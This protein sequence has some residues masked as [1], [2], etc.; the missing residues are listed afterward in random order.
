M[1]IGG[2]KMSES[3]YKAQIKYLKNNYKDFHINLRF[4][5]FNTFQD[6]CKKKNTTP[7]T[8]IKKFIDTYIKD[9]S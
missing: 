7:T 9:N 8:E 5:I 2:K 4:D 1:F 3:K 6:L